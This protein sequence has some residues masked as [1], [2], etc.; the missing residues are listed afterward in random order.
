MNLPW[1]GFMLS[2]TKM[3][4]WLVQGSILISLP[5]EIPGIFMTS[6]DTCRSVNLI[7]SLIFVYMWYDM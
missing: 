1:T 2:G 5:S 4:N 6:H 3:E 7:Y